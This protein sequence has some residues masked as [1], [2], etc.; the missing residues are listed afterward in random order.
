MYAHP[1]LDAAAAYA[2]AAKDNGGAMPAPERFDLLPEP[3]RR[4]ETPEQAARRHEIQQR[5]TNLATANPE[6]IADIIHSWMAQDE[7][8]R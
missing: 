3:G 2:L 6:A 4:G 7:R 5:M 1:W 8:K